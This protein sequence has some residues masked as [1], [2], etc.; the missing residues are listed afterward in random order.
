M[1][2][3]KRFLKDDGIILFT[4]NNRFGVETWNCNSP[5]NTEKKKNMS[6]KEIENTLQQLGIDNYK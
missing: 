3:A 4:C 6:K 5:E 1:I 2:F